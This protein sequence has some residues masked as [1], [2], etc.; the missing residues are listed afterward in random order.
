MLSFSRLITSGHAAGS[1][2]F[3]DGKLIC[4]QLLVST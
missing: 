3:P 4:T 1:A 2:T